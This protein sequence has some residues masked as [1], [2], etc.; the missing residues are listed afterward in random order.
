LIEVA[1]LVSLT[2][3]TEVVKKVVLMVEELALEMENELVEN[4]VFDKVELKGKET[5]IQK[6]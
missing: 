5:E 1:K 4:S 3:N 2:G 6:A